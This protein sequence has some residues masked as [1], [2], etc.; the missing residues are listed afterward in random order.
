MPGSIL[1]TNFTNLQKLASNLVTDLVA[2]GFV[3]EH[4]YGLDPS[5][6]TPVFGSNSAPS[7]TDASAFYVLRPTKAV[8]PLCVEDTDTGDVNYSLRQPWRL[9]IFA[10]DWKYSNLVKD[11]I[12]VWVVPASQVIVESSGVVRVASYA[13]GKQSGYLTKDNNVLQSTAGENSFF[14]RMLAQ[15]APERR[16]SC[17]GSPTEEYSEDAQSVPLSYLI[18]VTDHG[19]AFSVWAENYDSAGDCFNWFTV[20]RFI[21]DDGTILLDEKS[22]LI[23][24]FT[25]NGGGKPDSGQLD[26]EG[27]LYFT[28]SEN[29][30]HAPTPPLSAVSP[31]A[32]SMPFINSM[33]QVGIMANRNFVM[34]FPRGINTQRFYY[35]YKLDM[36]GFSSADVLSHKSLQTLTVNNEERQFRSINAN[37]KNNTGMRPLFVV[38][39]SGI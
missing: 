23:C 8:D 10:A 18:S 27:I 39:G 14:S 32:D 21:K 9:V 34:L 5:T 35:P 2:F 7:H 28:V 15:I 11:H 26:S 33:Q 38:K 3:V 24:I 36:V 6:G 16:W 1:R 20:Q 12:K 29:D 31:S 25:Q 30:I 37:S 13:E 4:A 19:I 22:P 17:F